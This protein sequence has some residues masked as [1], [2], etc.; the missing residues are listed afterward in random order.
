M[1]VSSSCKFVLVCGCCHAG[2]LNT[3]VKSDGLIRIPA[4]YEGLEK[5]T[6][7]DVILW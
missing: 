4:E 7:V 6:A 5:G 3:L 1:Y 2:L